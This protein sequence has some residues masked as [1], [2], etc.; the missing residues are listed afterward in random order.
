MLIKVQSHLLQRISSSL[1]VDSELEVLKITPWAELLYPYRSSGCSGSC[2]N[3]RKCPT[4]EI[5]EEEEEKRPSAE[6]RFLFRSSKVG[7][8][9]LR[10]KWRGRGRG[11][12]RCSARCWGLFFFFNYYDCNGKVVRDFGTRCRGILPLP[13]RCDA[14]LQLSED[15]CAFKPGITLGGGAPPSGLWRTCA[16]ELQMDPMEILL[17]CHTQTQRARA[18]ANTS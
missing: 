15:F 13:A 9:A 4:N 18:H 10:E 3:Q 2:P 17:N 8:K 6:R 16:S 12:S 5:K 7:K 14:L 11:W 1:S